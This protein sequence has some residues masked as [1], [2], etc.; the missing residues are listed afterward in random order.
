MFDG[1]NQYLFRFLPRDDLSLL[2]LNSNCLISL[3]KHS[4][5]EP[6]LTFLIFG[7]T[8]RE[9]SNYLILRFH[10]TSFKFIFAPFIFAANN[11]K[12]KEQKRIIKKNWL[13]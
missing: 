3:C 9:K 12:V 11:K 1:F 6:N 2:K 7:K 8:K 10:A 13:F 4:K 5:S